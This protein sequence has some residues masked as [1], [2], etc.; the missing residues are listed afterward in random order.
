MKMKQYSLQELYSRFSEFEKS[1][2]ELDNR[3]DHLD[4]K[5][6]YSMQRIQDKFEQL[7]K[8]SKLEKD[9]TSTVYWEVVVYR[10]GDKLII[11]KDGEI[12]D[13][14]TII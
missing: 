9:D 12:L 5:Y 14:F 3:L 6:S 1:L 10:L 13:E 8:V 7:E 4:M 2:K 11:R